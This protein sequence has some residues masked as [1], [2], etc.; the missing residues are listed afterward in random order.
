MTKVN[1]NF[2]L[3]GKNMGPINDLIL[4]KNDRAKINRLA[5]IWA[6]VNDKKMTLADFFEAFRLSFPEECQKTWFDIIGKKITKKT[7]RWEE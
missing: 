7:K 1:I 3:T 6:S 4:D 2:K 5:V